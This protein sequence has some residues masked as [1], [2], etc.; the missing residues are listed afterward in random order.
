MGGE[1]IGEGDKDMFDGKLGRDEREKVAG[2]GGI[3]NAERG[4]V[5]E[6]GV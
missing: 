1:K 6:E 5:I 2:K 4:K 3:K